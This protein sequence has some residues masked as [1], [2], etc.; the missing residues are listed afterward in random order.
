MKRLFSF[1]LSLIITATFVFPNAVL[2]V[3]DDLDDPE[4]GLISQN[5][6]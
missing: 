5:E 2:A 3:N 1:L 4:D 6:A